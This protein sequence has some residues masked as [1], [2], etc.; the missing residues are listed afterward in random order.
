MKFMKVSRGISNANLFKSSNVIGW[1]ETA[2]ILD[3]DRYI[4]INDMNMIC[5]KNSRSFWKS[6]LL[7][8]NLDEN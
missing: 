3:T 8:K 7:N 5:Q 6:I 2:P 4:S 1:L